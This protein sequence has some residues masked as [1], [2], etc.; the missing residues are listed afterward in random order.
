LLDNPNPSEAAQFIQLSDITTNELHPAFKKMTKEQRR[1]V[2][3]NCGVLMTLHLRHI[4]EQSL[5][6]LRSEIL[7]VPDLRTWCFDREVTLEA[8]E[9]ERNDTMKTHTLTHMSDTQS[10]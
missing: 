9:P 1:R 7:S 3:D 10:S 5:D 4:V 6:F 2:L 8:E